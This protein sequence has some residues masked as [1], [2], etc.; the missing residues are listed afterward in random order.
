MV[1]SQL[2]L[3]KHIALDQPSD[4]SRPKKKCMLRDQQPTNPTEQI[5]HNLSSRLDSKMTLLKVTLLL[6]IASRARSDGAPSPSPSPLPPMFLTGGKTCGDDKQL[7]KD[8]KCCGAPPSKVVT[9]VVPYVPNFKTEF[10]LS[11]QQEVSCKLPVFCQCQFPVNK[12][13][14]LAAYQNKDNGLNAFL[15]MDIWTSN[16]FAFNAGQKLFSGA[17]F[18]QYALDGS[19][20]DPSNASSVPRN[21]YVH[22]YFID[23]ESMYT[24]W[25]WYASNFM[26]NMLMKDGAPSVGGAAFI[27]PNDMSRLVFSGMCKSYADLLKKH[28]DDIGLSALYGMSIDFPVPGATMMARPSVPIESSVRTVDFSSLAAVNANSIQPTGWVPPANV[29]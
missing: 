8:D 5:C 6:A 13:Y 26:K 17:S 19:K 24:F 12:D 4:V 11:D 3:N 2:I 7:W 28:F 27:E 14:Y 1:M 20:F 16:A 18:S 9:D 25:K 29:M 15:L 23:S 21:L 22:E 10:A